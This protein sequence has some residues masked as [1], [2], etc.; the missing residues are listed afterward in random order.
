[1]HKGII[2]SAILAGAFLFVPPTF[3]QDVAPQTPAAVPQQPPATG[4]STSSAKVGDTVYDP[5]GNS[6]GTIKA[7]DGPN[8]VL[9]TGSVT[10][11]VPLSA[12]SQGRRDR[13]SRSRRQ[14]WK[15]KRKKTA[16]P[17]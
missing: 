10:V 4:Q 9:S 17:Q 3:A 14:N 15:P 8:A 1:M 16:P 13:P 11:G 7:L 5:G 12:I 2:Q 6:V